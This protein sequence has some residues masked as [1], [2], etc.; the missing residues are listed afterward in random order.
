[1]L[2]GAVPGS[3]DLVD[4]DYI[5]DQADVA[6]ET[7]A[8]RNAAAASAEVSLAGAGDQGGAAAAAA[9]LEGGHDY[10]DYGH[11]TQPGEQDLMV[12]AATDDTGFQDPYAVPA[13]SEQPVGVQPAGGHTGG[14]EGEVTEYLASQETFSYDSPTPD[15]S[16]P[17]T[18]TAAAVD[19]SPGGAA[20]GAV[21]NVGHEFLFNG[22]EPGLDDFGGTD[23]ST[24]VAGG[25]GTAVA[26][27][28]AAVLG[29]EGDSKSPGV[30]NNAAGAL[31]L[32]LGLDL[33]RREENA[34]MRTRARSTSDYSAQGTREIARE[35]DELGLLTA[36]GGEYDASTPSYG[37]DE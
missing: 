36:G 34:T 32:G 30:G 13:V 5:S 1:M 28:D 37:L 17:D 33:G 20:T 31:A 3:K 24:T 7:T 15:A 8:W 10:Y 2:D 27:E 22:E 11:Q 9:F 12:W 16:S 25:G 21:N 4:F 14:G 19:T 23:R 18:T 26:P 6:V 29:E 35:I